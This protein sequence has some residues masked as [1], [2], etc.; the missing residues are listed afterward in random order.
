MTDGLILTLVLSLKMLDQMLLHADKLQVVVVSENNFYHPVLPMLAVVPIVDKQ[1][2][3][4]YT[5]CYSKP[6]YTKGTLTQST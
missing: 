2:S 4:I 5:V 3:C 1:N 6:R